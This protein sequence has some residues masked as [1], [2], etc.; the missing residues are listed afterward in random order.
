MDEQECG[1]NANLRQFQ[2]RAPAIISPIICLYLF[3][4]GL[5][6]IYFLSSLKLHSRLSDS[7]TVDVSM[8]R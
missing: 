7:V 2:K 3:E 8:D 1:K 4:I 5:V 6:S